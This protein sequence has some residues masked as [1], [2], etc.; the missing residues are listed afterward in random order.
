MMM[1]LKM[2]KIALNIFGGCCFC[3]LSGATLTVVRMHTLT[4]IKIDTAS[5]QGW[6][7]GQERQGEYCCDSGDQ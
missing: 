4:S 3:W 2:M 5:E 6:S 7:E 1:I